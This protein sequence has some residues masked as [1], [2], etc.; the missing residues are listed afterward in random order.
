MIKMRLPKIGIVKI[1]NGEQEKIKPIPENDKNQF[2]SGF[3][4]GYIFLFWFC[5]PVP[6]YIF[7]QTTTWKS[8]A[9]PAVGAR[10]L[11]VGRRLQHC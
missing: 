1:N 9:N 11:V 6:G 4:F 5:L 3:R 8:T 7:Q 10:M 2:N